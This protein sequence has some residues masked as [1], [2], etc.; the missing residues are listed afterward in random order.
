MGQ[1]SG[2][3]D[4]QFTASGNRSRAEVVEGMCRSRSKLLEA[5]GGQVCFCSAAG[6]LYHSFVQGMGYPRY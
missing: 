1:A 5:W 2:N 6:M 4:S 3:P